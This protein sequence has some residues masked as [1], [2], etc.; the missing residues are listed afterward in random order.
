MTY[1]YYNFYEIA[2]FSL[3]ILIIYILKLIHYLLL[4]NSFETIFPDSTIYYKQYLSK[5]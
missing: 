4:L 1:N 3:N 5:I 2:V